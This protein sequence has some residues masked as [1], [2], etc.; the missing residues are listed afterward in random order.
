MTERGPRYIVSSCTFIHK[1][2]QTIQHP[3][4]CSLKLHIT[5]TDNGYTKEANTM[6]IFRDVTEPANIRIRRMRIAS[7]GCGFHV[8]HPSDADLSRDQNYQLL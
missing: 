6:L 3:D 1:Q 4:I 8:Q 7:V 2:Q 5:N